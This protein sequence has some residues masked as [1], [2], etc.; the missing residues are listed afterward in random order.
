MPTP[1]KAFADVAA[2]YGDVD[3][4]DAAAVLAF[5]TETFPTLPPD[6]IDEIL[7]EL[8]AREGPC[9]GEPDTAAY[10]KH[11]PLPDLADSPPADLP[12]LAAGWRAMLCRLLRI[13][14]TRGD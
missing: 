13:R 2:R 9:E 10:P 8:L 5:F 3:A 1:P 11:A 12:A 6:T 7:D 14:S 4:G